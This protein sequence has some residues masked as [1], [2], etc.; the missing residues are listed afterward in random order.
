MKFK[1]HFYL[2]SEKNNTAYHSV[3]NTS[4]MPIKGARI[5]QVEMVS[6]IHDESVPD[7]S[8]LI[9]NI[10]VIILKTN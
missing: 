2:A 4:E 1:F 7:S 6:N 5:L 10:I 8:C 9:D 3:S